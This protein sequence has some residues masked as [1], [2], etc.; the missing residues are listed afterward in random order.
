M[1]KKKK[2]AT[3]AKNGKVNKSAEIRKYLSKKPKAGPKEI[4]EALG[5]SGI[6]VTPGFVSTIKTAVNKKKGGRKKK[7]ARGGQA[8]TDRVSL[9]TLVQAKKLIDEIGGVEKA[10]DALNALA[11]LR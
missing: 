10:K 8:T 7:S 1:A 9:S 5:Q 3:K 4:T 11:R 2:S 6:V